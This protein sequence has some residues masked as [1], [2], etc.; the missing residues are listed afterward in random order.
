VPKL[1]AFL[2]R[3]AVLAG[4]LATPAGAQ[5]KPTSA[6]TAPEPGTAAA[7][8]RGLRDKAELEGFVDGLLTAYMNDKHIAG[9]TV[10]VVKDG[11]IFFAKGY[12][13]ADV[14]ARKPVDAA[15]S[16]FR[17][18]S[19]SK[20]FTWTAV[21]QL[22]EQ[23]KLDLKKDI[24]EYLDFKIP[25]TFPQPITLEHV[26][27]HTPGL[28]EDGRDLFTEDPAHITPMSKW[29]PEHMPKRVRPPGTFSS[30]SNWATAVAG[31]IV[32]RVSGMPWDDYIEKKIIEPLGMTHTTTRQPLPEKFA[33]DMS[34]GYR[35]RDGQYDPRKFEIV[36]GAAPAGSISASA[37]DMTRFMLAHLGNGAL[38]DVRILGDSTAKVM[39]SQLF[40]HDKRLPGFAHGFYEQSSHGLRIFG[41]GGDTGVFHSDMALIPSENLG[42]FISTNTDTGGSISFQPFLAAFLDHYFPVDLPVLKPTEG[43]KE[44]AKRYAGDY[45][46][47]RM[48]FS[49]FQKALSL[50]SAIPITALPDGALLLKSPFGAIRLVSIDSLLFRD[51]N[52]GTLVAFRE[53]EN[54][55]ITH[56]FMDAAPMMT[57]DKQPGLQSPT[58]HR[59]LLISSLVVFI[60]IVVAAVLRFFGRRSLGSGTDSSVTA[61]RRT[62]VTVSLLQIGF[63]LFLVQ[64]ATSLGGGE[65]RGASTAFKVGLALP[66]I[67][68]ILTLVAAWHVLSEWRRGE[69]TLGVRLRGTLAVAIALA[70]FWSLNHWQLLGW[71]V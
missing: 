59:N 70:W 48:S 17:I 50:A 30:Y 52:S 16:M 49:T 33:A 47:N 35:Y 56:G 37:V 34:K 64:F 23:G 63:V 1:H 6:A 69:G 28:E 20:L 46:F 26:L 45:L 11:Q 41:H 58:F 31:Y 51:V 61:A 10:S 7:P 55:R 29:L 66:V 36:T 13:Y 62:M 42:V 40:T 57:L 65:F 21:M 43:A 27:T 60:L 39:H 32:E 8:A 3:S 22:A 5:P 2:T 68:L 12:G 67:G 15:T 25:A 24:N 53:D 14:D 54:H 44:G 9:V 71:H 19:I 38:G 18:G 4:L